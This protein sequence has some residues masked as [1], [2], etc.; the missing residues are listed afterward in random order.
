MRRRIDVAEKVQCPR[1]GA[2][3]VDTRQSREY[4]NGRVFKRQ[5]PLVRFLLFVPIASVL[6]LVS[7]KAMLAT[8]VIAAIWAGMAN[9]HNK[10]GMTQT[11]PKEMHTCRQC[12]YSWAHAPGM[13]EPAPFGPA[14]G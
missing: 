13:P 6:E 12:G 8:L 7:F 1:C 9:W 14:A 5:M 11:L 4:G 3:R 2:N 10:R